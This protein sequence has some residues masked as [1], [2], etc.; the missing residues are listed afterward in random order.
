[1]YGDGTIELRP[2]APLS[3]FDKAVTGA[4]SNVIA[5]WSSP[6]S[7]RRRSY[8]VSA[9]TDSSHVILSGYALRTVSVA[10][11]QFGLRTKLPPFSAVHVPSSW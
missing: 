4:W 2:L 1:M 6:W 7:A 9:V 3:T 8:I 11:S 5:N 10:A